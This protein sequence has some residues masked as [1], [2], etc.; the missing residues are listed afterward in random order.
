MENFR[1]GLW[2]LN[3]QTVVVLKIVKTETEADVPRQ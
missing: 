3:F 1:Q 2:V